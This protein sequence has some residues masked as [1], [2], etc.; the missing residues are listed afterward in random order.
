MY[1]LH[2]DLYCTYLEL[3]AFDGLGREGFNK[4]LTCFFVSA[5]LEFMLESKKAIWDLIDTFK[6]RFWNIYETELLFTH[7]LSICMCL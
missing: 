2:K 6:S 5:Y 4:F 3:Y 7:I 1:R